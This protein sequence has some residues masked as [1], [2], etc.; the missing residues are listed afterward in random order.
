MVV[1]LEKNAPHQVVII[2]GGFGGLYTAKTLKKANVNVTLIDKR[3]FHLFQP[4]LYQVATGTLSPGDISSPL[5]AVFSKSKNTQVLLGE[6]KDI[7]PKA[8]QVIL[9]DKIVPYDTLIVATGANHSYFGK[10]HWKDVAPGLKTVEDAIEMRRR[11][12]GAFEAAESENDPEKRR[13]WLTFV[14]VGGGPTGVELAGAIAELAYKTLKEDFRSIDTSE[15]KILL[16][17][18][19]DR[20]L[21][22]I[23]PE[24]SQVATESL[25]KLGAIIQTKTRVTNIENDI[26]TF[27]QGDEVKEIPSKTILWAA[28]V[29]ASPMGEV[30][31]QRTGVECDHAGRVMVEPDLTIRGYKNIFVVGDLGNF[32]HQ[33]GKP[34]P[35]VAPVATQQGEYVAK[36]IKRR[37]KGHTLP[38]FRYNDVGSLAMIGQNLAVVDLGLIKLQGFIAWVFWLLIHIYFLIEFDTKLLVVFQWA[39][40]YITRNRRSRLITGR[41]AFVQAKNVTKQTSL[42]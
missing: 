15:T 27:K 8:Q 3:N 5:R 17:Q 25:Q 36:L 16:L 21:P 19:G 10:D 22:H 28:G 41:E 12:F 9:D 20:I 42:S 30:L 39:W 14:I 1:S 35:G 31:A 7:N 40:N 29:K 37:L 2:G 4:L 33:N 34:L 11:I 6:V 13:A 26:V 38:Q 32:S 24:L 18:G 23:A